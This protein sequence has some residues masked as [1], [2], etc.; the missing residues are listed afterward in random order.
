M[1]DFVTRAETMT[2]GAW[3]QVLMPSTIVLD[4]E[5][6]SLEEIATVA[7]GG[8]RVT[9]G[10]AARNKLQRASS[11]IEKLHSSCA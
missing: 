9:L 5:H 3:G 4:G 6:L 7:R 11:V 1:L 10:D 8:A 2:Q